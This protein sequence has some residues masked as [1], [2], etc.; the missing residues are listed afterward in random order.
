MYETQ[1]KKVIN[2]L[3]KADL[4]ASRMGNLFIAA[5]IIIA[6]ALLLVM[7][8]FPGSVKR[9]TQYQLRNAQHVIYMD[10]N[11]NQMDS[12][13]QDDRIAY[14]TYDKTGERMEIEDYMIW[15]TYYDGNSKTI[16]TLEFEEGRLPEKG[17]E[18]I[19]PKALMKKLGKPAEIGTK[20]VLPSLSGKTETCT[21]T[22][23]MKFNGSKIYPIVYS[24][25]Y[26]DH[27]QFLKNV[28]YDALVKVQDGDKMTQDEFEETIYG[29]GE[30]AGIDRMNIN[31]NNAYWG[32][33]SEGLVSG[34]SAA[35]GIIGF[36]ILTAGIMVIYSVFYISITGK[37]RE[38]GQLRT[39][40][41]TRKQ[42][43]KLVRKEGLILGIKSVPIGIVLGGLITY[44][45]KP[46]GFS[47]I[48]FLFA[49]LLTLVIVLAVIMLS[50]MKPAKMASAV[51][52]IEAARYTAYTGESGKKATRKIQRKLT[53]FHLAKMNAFR[54]R[55][56][57]FVTVL[58]L[59]LSGVLF[60]GGA[61][62]MASF[63]KEQFARQGEF[64]IGEFLL[65]ISENALNTA[66]HGQTEI[67]MKSPFTESFYQEI[68]GISG[69]TKVER[70]QQCEITY[71]YKDVKRGED[72]ISQFTENEAQT[73]QKHVE[74]GSVDYN[75]MIQGNKIA[76][77]NNDVV[78]EIFGWR[79]ELGDKVTIHY[80]NGK[81]QIK[82][83]EIGAILNSDFDRTV[84]F[85]RGWFTLPDRELTAQTKGINLDDIWIVATD[86]AKTNQVEG[87]IKQALSSR[88]D[89]KLTT[90]RE[91]AK[92]SEESA[93]QM[94][95]LIMALVSFVTLF[96]LINLINT[97]I[98]N[99]LSQKTELAMLQS[100]GM[101]GKQV[102]HMVI[103]EGAV[104]AIGN[105]L[106]AVIG[107][108]LLGLGLCKLMNH[109]GAEYMIYNFP[110]LYIVG[111]IIAI[112]AI[113]CIIAAVEIR[114][115]N[116][117][118]I[119]ERLRNI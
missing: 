58:S 34:D 61:T 9:D 80:W 51:S 83:Y 93:N 54:N 112:L 101:T 88:P 26:A 102:K 109:L 62:Y 78:E 91:H 71:D 29:I 3:A 27:G 115:Y 13:K 97:L 65:S 79:F 89:L 38:Y 96:S 23:F 68:N 35:I 5:T 104:L 76:V 2:H 90:L 37:T 11:Q 66:K 22:G 87:Q 72:S 111:Y 64:K 44:C 67:Q 1:N 82:T 81:E 25:A 116:K 50:V 45:I 74:E 106:I 56:K 49:A 103:G 94:F 24:K 19:V 16:K 107:G 43:R 15:R 12:L 30:T 17:H 4:R 73:L 117:I 75:D 21:V 70:R 77:M 98:T 118:S 46:D 32:T 105:S 33:L 119:V 47:I 57:T 48:V 53:P 8:L 39:L 114:K 60:I 113:P 86:P 108:S 14:T 95:L 41:M 40:G 92:Q 10:L 100:I 84:K 36:I 20:I 6:T 7:G 69:V 110:V 55:K 28:N 31:P 42:I 85:S 52:P 99:F 63:D 18:V 59:G